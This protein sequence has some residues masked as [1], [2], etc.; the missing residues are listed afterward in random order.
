MLFEGNIANESCQFKGDDEDQTFHL[1]AFID[2]QLVSVASMYFE[3]HPDIE[4]PYQYQ[5]QG[6]LGTDLSEP[7][8]QSGLQTSS[9]GQT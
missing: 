5:L 6:I 2:G 8:C 4:E 7:L 9:L 1:G 3:K